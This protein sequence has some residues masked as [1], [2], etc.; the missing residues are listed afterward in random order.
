[1]WDAVVGVGVDGERG[2]RARETQTVARVAPLRGRD[3]RRMADWDRSP[4]GRKSLY[5]IIVILIKGRRK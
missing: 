4:Q 5:R 2:H 3:N 1:M